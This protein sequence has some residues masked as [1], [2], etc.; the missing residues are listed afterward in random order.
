[1]KPWSWTVAGSIDT[2]V[3]AGL[4]P[5]SI[6]S[7]TRVQRCHPARP[8]GAEHATGAT[9]APVV[10]RATALWNRG[11]L[12][13]SGTL[14]IRLQ[15]IHLCQQIFKQ[16]RPD[17]MGTISLGH[18]SEAWTLCL[19]VSTSFLWVCS[20]S[21]ASRVAWSEGVAQA[22]DT[23]NVDGAVLCSGW[24]RPI[25]STGHIHC[26]F[27]EC[28]HTG[29]RTYQPV[30]VCRLACPA[31]GSKRG[32]ACPSPLDGTVFGVVCDKNHWIVVYLHI[33]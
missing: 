21:D 33:F 19:L 26:I 25:Q 10:Q 6:I 12:T 8:Q 13:V 16:R 27:N 32:T 30:L 2:A 3:R 18:C 22:A 5:E 9:G 23:P 31:N 7:E 20:T 24:G 28:R 1:M 29:C 4:V 14:F 17:L 11:R 15:S